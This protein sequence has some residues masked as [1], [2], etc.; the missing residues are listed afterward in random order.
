M[1]YMTIYSSEWFR[2]WM[3]GV[4]WKSPRKQ[5]DLG[6]NSYQGFMCRTSFKM[7]RHF[8]SV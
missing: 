5:W 8:T 1:S 6:A 7:T 3:G 4:V 2:K